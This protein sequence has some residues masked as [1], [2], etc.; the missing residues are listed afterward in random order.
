MEPAGIPGNPLKAGVTTL[1]VRQFNQLQSFETEFGIFE[2]PIHPM[3]FG[4]GY[5]NTDYP[6]NPSEGSSQFLSVTRNLGWVMRCFPGHSGR[7][8]PANTFRW[9]K[10]VWLNSGS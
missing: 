10:A 1:M 2:R 8:K 5:D 6:N 9:E 7:S 3:E 4:I